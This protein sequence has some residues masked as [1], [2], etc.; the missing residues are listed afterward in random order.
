M[1]VISV[2]ATGSV[3]EDTEYLQ[4]A[5]NNNSLILLSSNFYITKPLIINGYKEIRGEPSNSVITYV[6]PKINDPAIN[7]IDRGVCL[8]KIQLYLD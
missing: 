6:G 4:S 3:D 5:I 2:C 7:V 1:S 8:K